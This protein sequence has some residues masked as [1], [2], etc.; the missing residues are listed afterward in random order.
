M[1]LFLEI[2]GGIIVLAVLIG[3]I[4]TKHPIKALFSSG[5]QGLCALAAVNIVGAM[6]GITV[7]LTAFTA[8]V[9]LVLGIPGVA[10]LLVLNTICFY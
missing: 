3:A 5:I 10:T 9:C 8:L 7:G 2:V 6:T 4:R 1:T